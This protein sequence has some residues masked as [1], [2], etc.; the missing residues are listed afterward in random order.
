DGLLLRTRDGGRT[1]QL[2][3]GEAQPEALEEFGFLEA[4]KN[5]GLY[6]VKVAG[7]YGVVVGDTGMVLTTSDG[8]DSWTRLELPDKDR[9]V[10]MRDVSLVPGTHGFTVGASG[11]S[12]LIDQ[13]RVTLPNGGTATAAATP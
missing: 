7:Q 9:L 8:G 3:R 5:P 13:N 2:Q 4:L 10:W 12:A 6:A 1:W 11:F